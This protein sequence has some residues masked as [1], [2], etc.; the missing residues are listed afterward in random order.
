M[1]ANLGAIGS[2]LLFLGLFL[3]LH[4]LSSLESMYGYY[5]IV[6]WFPGFENLPHALIVSHFDR[7]ESV[8]M[9]K[10]WP[11]QAKPTFCLSCKRLATICKEMKSSFAGGSSGEQVTLVPVTSLRVRSLLFS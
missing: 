8:Y 5:R 10:S 3:S 2:P 6:Y 11:S 9:E 7:V 1:A 4:A